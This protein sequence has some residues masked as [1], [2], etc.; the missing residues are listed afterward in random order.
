ML[1][2]LTTLLLTLPAPAHSQEA[3]RYTM[4]PSGNGIVRLDSQT[5]AVSI[6][7]ERF[8]RWVCRS[9]ADDKHALQRE[10]D[11]LTE[12]NGTLRTKTAGI[13]PA[14]RTKLQKEVERLTEENRALKEKTA[15]AA[16]AGRAKL[17]KKIERLNAEN[18]ALR[19]KADDNAADRT[20]LQKQMEQLTE[21]NRELK[22]QATKSAA[23]DRAL[24]QREIEGLTEE[25]RLLKDKIGRPEKLPAKT[26]A[27]GGE[28]AEQGHPTASDEQDIDQLTTFFEKMMRRFR[29]MAESLRNRPRESGL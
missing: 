16:A 17:Q 6:C 23:A 1:A 3:G 8:K 25:F 14:G 2:V 7:G 9:V 20:Q 21:E 24:L 12:E 19:E 26:L 15:S 29:D 28:A 18:R 4:A 27:K 5:G 22:E 11:R 13:T 10:I